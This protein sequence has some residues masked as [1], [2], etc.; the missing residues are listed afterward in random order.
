[1]AFLF[2]LLPLLGIQPLLDHPLPV[3]TAAPKA[4]TQQTL[5]IGSQSSYW[6]A[7]DDAYWNL[8]NGSV[9]FSTPLQLRVGDRGA[10]SVLSLS[11]PVFLGRCVTTV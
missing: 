5:S 10:E 11:N 8:P 2:P 4:I 1:M 6:L 3:V 7:S 9:R